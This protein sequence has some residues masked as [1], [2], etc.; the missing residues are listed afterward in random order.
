[1]R[2]K[3]EWETKHLTVSLNYQCY[4]NFFDSCDIFGGTWS[5][6]V[7][8]GTEYAGTLYGVLKRAKG[9]QNK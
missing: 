4:K 6:V 1:M 3:G 9:S 5:L 8:S 7:Y 2:S